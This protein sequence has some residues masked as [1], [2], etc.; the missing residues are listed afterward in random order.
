MKFVKENIHDIVRLM[1][2]QVALAVFGLVLVSAARMANGAVGVLAL[3]ASIVAILFYMYILYATMQEIGSKH[4]V[5]VDGN[6]MKRDNFWGLKVMTLAQIPTII[7]LLLLFIGYIFMIPLGS[8]EWCRVF[9][10]N[11]YALS[12]IVVAFLQS[13]YDG[14]IS[15]FLFKVGLFSETR[16]FLESNIGYGSLVYFFCFLLSLVP[17]L[18]VCWGSYVMG[19]HDKKLISLFIRNNTEN[20]DKQ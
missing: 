6:R 9:G 20:S 16:G 8:A 15:F 19:L 2:N 4:R 18:L 11:L 5:R 7:V 17:G 1:L 13:M 12:Q 10:T 3:V 14:L